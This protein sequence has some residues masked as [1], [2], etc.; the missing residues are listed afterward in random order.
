LILLLSNPFTS[1]LHDALVYLNDV[2][3]RF[4]LPVAVSSYAL[5]IIAIAVIIKVLTYPLTSAQQRSMRAMQELQPKLKALQDRHKD[6]RE[7]QAQ[8]QMELYR[9]HG[10]NP[11]GGCLPLIIQMVVL[12]GLFNAIRQLETEGLL[13]GQR[14]LWIP[15]LSQCEPSPMCGTD[16]S[17]LPIAL[18]IMIV[19]LVVSQLL[20]Q[21]FLTPPS[22]D[23][24]AQAMNATMK[25]MPLFFAFIFINL[26]AGLVLY[27]T[28]FNLVSIAQY[29]AVDRHRMPP[30]PKA[31]QP[32]LET[33]ANPSSGAGAGKTTV[34]DKDTDYDYDARRER[35]R[36]KRH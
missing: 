2:I 18:P 35:R 24:Q 11:F 4:E 10:V 12:F 21:K 23:P 27:Y 19:L 28:A 16:H 29:L 3:G 17:L 15:D 26:P 1:I 20:Y 25:W 36:K 5:A 33:V 31:L 8:A 30:G 7:K 9:A 32:V 22:V 14:F 6:D 13:T 34:K